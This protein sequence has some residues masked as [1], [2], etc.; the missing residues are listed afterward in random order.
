MNCVGLSSTTW[1]CSRHGG[2]SNAAINLESGSFTIGDVAVLSATALG[3]N[4]VS[5]SL[6]SVGTLTSLSVGA[7]DVTIYDATNDA[8]PSIFLGSSASDRSV[9]A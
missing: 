1:D 9:G 6:T 2:D 7:G 5:S 8:N 3:S 4:V